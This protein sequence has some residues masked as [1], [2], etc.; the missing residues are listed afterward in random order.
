MESWLIVVL[1]VAAV[2]LV[3]LLVAGA[4]RRRSK[5]ERRGAARSERIAA[6]KHRARA[7]VSEELL[8]ERAGRDRLEAV[9]HELR[10]REI[11]PDRGPG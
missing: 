4:R 2:V 7:E 10:A 6:E 5:R 8:R 11:D 3:T 1:V 9:V